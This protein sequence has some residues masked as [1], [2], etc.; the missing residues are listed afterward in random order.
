MRPVLPLNA[1][2]LMVAECSCGGAISASSTLSLPRGD[3]S[4]L[5]DVV[6]VQPTA[7]VLVV[8]GPAEDEKH[9]QVNGQL[10]FPALLYRLVGKPPGSNHLLLSFKTDCDC[11]EL[12][13]DTGMNGRDFVSLDSGLHWSEVQRLGRTNEATGLVRPCM[14]VDSQSKSVCLTRTVHSH[15]PL[16][17]SPD[18]RTAYLAAQVFDSSSGN[19]LALFNASLRFPF[20]LSAYSRPGTAFTYS[21][22]TDGNTLRQPDGSTLMTLY[23]TVAGASVIVA[24]RSTDQGHSWDYRGTVANSSASPE[25]HVSSQ[26][27]R[28]TET[29]MAFLADERTILSVWRSIGTNHPLCG[30]TSEDFGIS[31]GTPRPLNGPFGVEPKLL[32]VKVG[33]Q[34]VLVISSGR[35]GLFL[36]FAVSADWAR[37]WQPFNLAAAHN[38]LVEDSE[39]HFPLGFVNGTQKSCRTAA[40][41]CSTSY[42]GLA[43]L[44]NNGSEVAGNGTG[45]E[46]LVSYDL[47]NSPNGTNFI[48]VMR[49]RLSPSSSGVAKPTPAVLGVEQASER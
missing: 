38:A 4:N 17:R 2:L 37:E 27:S 1:W 26:C 6:Q 25:A 11:T 41:A 42:T 19:Q 36:H 35:V 32:R 29:S 43:E 46:I 9:A 21:L 22:G 13:I 10:W 34:S 48:Y 39:Q 44:V 8:S 7:P 23:G 40:L 12:P 33:A 49:L 18:N 16:A 15:T 28:P 30:S 14:M 20:E 5:A 31:F 24:M 47:I 3:S 45:A